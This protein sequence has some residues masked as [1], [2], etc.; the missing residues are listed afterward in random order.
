MTV[1][2]LELEPKYDSEGGGVIEGVFVSEVAAKNFR[3]SGF[4]RDFNEDEWEF[5]ITEW[6]VQE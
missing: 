5:R 4:F 3:D 1:W 6:N 2:I